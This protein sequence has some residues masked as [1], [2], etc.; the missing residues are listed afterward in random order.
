MMGAHTFR[1]VGILLLLLEL[2]YRTDQP[3]TTL[4][5]WPLFPIFMMLERGY[6]A[7]SWLCCLVQRGLLSNHLHDNLE[8]WDTSKAVGTHS[9]FHPSFIR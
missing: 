7:Q 5:P 2:P 6:R 8:S 4:G 9:C 3:G 1:R